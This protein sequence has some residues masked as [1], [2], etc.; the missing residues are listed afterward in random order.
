MELKVSYRHMESSDAIQER[1]RSKVIK[2][3]KYFQGKILVDWKCSNDSDGHKSEVSVTGDHFTYH[4]TAVDGEN[5]F[6]S[7]DSAIEKL[8]TQLSKKSDKV[9][10][11]IHRPK[12]D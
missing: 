4:A 3:K 10:D 1:I 2:L 5:F 9:K 8:R 11:K 12:V 6:K 7:I